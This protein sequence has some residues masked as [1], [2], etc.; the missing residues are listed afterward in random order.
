MAFCACA[1]EIALWH[2]FI[3]QCGFDATV[4]MKRLD[5]EHGFSFL[6]FGRVSCSELGLVV[7]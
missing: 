2:I 6:V 5:V 3:R 7:R 1:V 4:R